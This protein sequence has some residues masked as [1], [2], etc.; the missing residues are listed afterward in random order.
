N[1]LRCF[2]DQLVVFWERQLIYDDCGKW[3]G[4]AYGHDQEG[5]LQFVEEQL[6]GDAKLA[7][8]LAPLVLGGFSVGRNEHCP[9]G[10]RRK[11]KRCHLWTVEEIRRQVVRR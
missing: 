2:L 3:P 9:C 10:S 8:A 11:F 5:Y 1:A 7:G 4:S 6:G